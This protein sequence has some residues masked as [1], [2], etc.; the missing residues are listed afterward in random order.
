MQNASKTL[1]VICNSSDLDAIRK[2]I[3]MIPKHL[4]SIEYRLTRKMFDAM[5]SNPEY[6]K[7]LSELVNAELNLE[8]LS[9]E[10]SGEIG[11][12]SRAKRFITDLGKDINKQLVSEETGIC[13]ICMEAFDSI[14]IKLMGCGHVFCK[15]CLSNVLDNC[16]SNYSDFPVKCPTCNDLM[17]Y[18]DIEFLADGPERYNKLRKMAVND[19]IASNSDKM[20]YCLTVGCDGIGFISTAKTVCDMCNKEYCLACKVRLL[21]V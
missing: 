18:R 6:L 9:L 4:T 12:L 10:L 14:P 7:Q 1:S 8:N 17:A 5:I 11:E 20:C 16:L 19:Y 15:N 21:L 3:E 13:D 2:E